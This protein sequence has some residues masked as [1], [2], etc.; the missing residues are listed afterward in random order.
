M[1]NPENDQ[2]S[3][4]PD[5]RGSQVRPTDPAM[6]IV[7]VLGAAAVAWLLID[8]CY[9]WLPTLPWL[10]PLTFLGLAAVEV[11]LARRVS[12]WIERKDGASH[13][14]PLLIARCVVLAKA[15]SLAAA[16]FAGLYAG[17]TGWLLVQR[18]V[19]THAG[20]DLPAAMVGTIGSA[21]LIAGGLVLERACR[22]PPSA[23]D[24]SSPSRHPRP[25]TGDGA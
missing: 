13:F 16:I 18:A 23:E 17:M 11:V 1:A 25:H 15:S 5:D 6:L 14:D 7:V 24:D 9:G 12:A 19:L 22:V 20:E 2:P 21:A 10:P 3:H 8:R 4:Q